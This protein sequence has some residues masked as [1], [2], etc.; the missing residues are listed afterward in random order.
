MKAE[1]GHSKAAGSE[2]PPKTRVIPRWVMVIAAVVLAAVIIVIVY[3]YLARP[4]WVG[5]SG[6][7]FWDYLELLIVPAALAIVVYWLNRRQDERN[8]ESDATRERERQEQEVRRERERQATEEA[9]RVRDRKA[10]DAQRERELQVEEQRAQDEALQAYLDKMTEL[11]V[12]Y[13]LEERIATVENTSLTDERDERET[14]KAEA[15]RTVAWARTKT[16]LRRLD[17]YRKG[18]VLR[19]LNEAALIKKDCP[20]IDSLAGADL[21]GAVLEGSN[22]KGA[23]LK[24][25]VLREAVLRQAILTA[26]DLKEADLTDADL[27]DADLRGVF[28]Y[29]Q[30]GSKQQITN[31]ELEL[32]T[33][34]LEGTIMPDGSKHP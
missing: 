33:N 32:Q 34:F 17:G 9:N 31:E 13:G 4:G 2:E 25:V 10:Q 28:K 23:A 27:T 6:K 24:G 5:V 30:E 15:V 26:A 1:T 3:G 18:A 21:V 19:F 22:L 12:V 7:R 29:T 8:R 11:L 20:V 14:L 16:V